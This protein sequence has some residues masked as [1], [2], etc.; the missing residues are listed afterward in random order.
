MVAGF[1]HRR[2]VDTVAL[3]VGRGTDLE[4]QCATSV[5][6]ALGFEHHTT[7][8][9]MEEYPLYADLVVNW[10]HLA[11]GCDSIMGLGWGVYSQLGNLSSKIISGCSLDRVVGGT[12][13]YNLSTET[14]S[15][16]TFFPKVI[17]RNGFPPQLLERLLK[18]EVFGD[19]VQETLTRIQTVYES[20]SDLEFRRTWWFELFHRQRLLIGSIF[21]WQLCF[22][23]WPVVLHLDWQ[24]LKTTAAMPV[25]TLDK[26]Q[27]KYE[28]IG[29][30][31]GQL[32]R[33]P[34]DGNGFN[35]KPL[36]LGSRSQRLAGR[37]HLY[38]LQQEWRQWQQK[39]GY[40]RRH[41][42]R[43][44][45]INNPGWRTVRRQ[46]ERY[47]Q[48]VEHLFHKDVLDEILP[49]PNVAVKC[50]VDAINE[51]SSMKALLGFLLWSRNHL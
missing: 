33:L 46:A 8:I 3:T 12:S 31:F 37:L 48:P 34:L 21:G 51:P 19:L 29:T 7:A 32:T 43:T 1:L 11:N 17:N 24:F 36:Y 25:E 26:R 16:E 14:L 30:R 20:Y 35:T 23:A 49:T 9:S 22:G 6:R 18:R 47:R 38:R 2:G 40:E 28:L 13:T 45:D 15:F 44:F 10:E 41:Y 27:A 42:F 4:M 50:K 5:A 39:L